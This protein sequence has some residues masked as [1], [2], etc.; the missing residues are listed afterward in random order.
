MSR[1]NLSVQLIFVAYVVRYNRQIVLADIEAELN[2]TP[3][4]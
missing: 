3:K 1:V 4:G 2:K